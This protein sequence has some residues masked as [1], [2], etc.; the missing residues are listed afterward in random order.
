MNFQSFC[1]LS[2]ARILLLFNKT[3]RARAILAQVVADAPASVVPRNML[4]YLHAQGE[5]YREAAAHFEMALTLKPDDASTLF[6][7][8]FARQKLG[9]HAA[10]IAAFQNAVQ[11]NPGLDRAWFGLGMSFAALSKHEESISA[12]AQAA[13]LQPLNPHALY[14][15]G[16]QHHIL[17]QAEK[18]DGIIERLRKFDPHAT[19]QLMR[20]TGRQ[21]QA[22]SAHH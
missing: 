5:N 15:L 16:V 8:G 9:A 19:V 2:H 14:E 4:A 6:N 11:L 18:V 7:L 3:A 10:A 21:P 1:Q 13:R 17:G 12:Y 20:A 22:Q